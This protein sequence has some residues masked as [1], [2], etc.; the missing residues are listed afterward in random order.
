MFNFDVKIDQVKNYSITIR[1]PSVIY[2]WLC[3]HVETTISVC[4]IHKPVILQSK[5]R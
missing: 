1:K 4:Q 5:K 3:C 2:L